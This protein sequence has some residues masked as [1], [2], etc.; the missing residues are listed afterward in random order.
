MDKR[1]RQLC[2]IIKLDYNVDV[3]KHQLNR[4]TFDFANQLTLISVVG[5]SQLQVK[6]SIDIELLAYI[7]YNVMGVMDLVELMQRLTLETLPLILHFE[8]FEYREFI[9]MPNEFGILCVDQI[10]KMG[11]CL[12]AKLI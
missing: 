1:T 2:D 8:K 6:R 7:L 9:M 12:G 3:T 10:L 5:S 4:I 11:S